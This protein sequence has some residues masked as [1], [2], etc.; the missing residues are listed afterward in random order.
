M[1]E[2][3]LDFLD[4]LLNVFLAV[5]GDHEEIV[6]CLETDHS[7]AKEPDALEQRIAADN[8][9]DRKT[10]DCFLDKIFVIITLPIN[11]NAPSNGAP[12]RFAMSRS[13]LIRSA[14]ASFR[15][16]F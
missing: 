11:E 3:A 6:A 1:G 9:A 16:P 4:H 13:N 12:M 15:W 7:I 10:C 5:E 14:S 2:Q 8:I